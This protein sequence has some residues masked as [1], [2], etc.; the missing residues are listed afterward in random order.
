MHDYNLEYVDDDGIAL[1]VEGDRKAAEEFIALFR[2]PPKI[3]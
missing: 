3:A 1:T 2:L